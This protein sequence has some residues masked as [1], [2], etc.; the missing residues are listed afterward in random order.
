[1]DACGRLLI[2]QHEARIHFGQSVP[3]HDAL[4]EKFVKQAFPGLAAMCARLDGLDPR[5]VFRSD[6][7]VRFGIRT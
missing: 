4:D 7:A 6:F 5:G 1:M 3:R 2:I